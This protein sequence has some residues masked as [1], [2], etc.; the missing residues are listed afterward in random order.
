[1]AAEV[2]R[3][4]PAGGTGGVRPG[5]GG[6]GRLGERVPRSLEDILVDGLALHF[7]FEPPMR[8]RL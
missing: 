2:R 7:H 8:A 5:A 4:T 3:T 1:V 6:H